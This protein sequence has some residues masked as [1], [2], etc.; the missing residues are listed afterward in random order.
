LAFGKAKADEIRISRVV[1]DE[2]YVRG[3]IHE[4]VYSPRGGRL[5]EPNQ[6]RSIDFMVEKKSFRFPGL[7]M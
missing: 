5:T 2:Q 7:L 3:L 4:L 6:K 1:F